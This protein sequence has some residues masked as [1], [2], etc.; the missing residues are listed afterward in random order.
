MTDRTHFVPADGP[1]RALTMSRRA[2]LAAEALRAEVEDLLNDEITTLAL[3]SQDD[4]IRMLAELYLDLGRPV[5]LA[6]QIRALLT[7]G[8]VR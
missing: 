5:A 3:D 4:G 1:Y 6:T 2:A 7:A 8:G